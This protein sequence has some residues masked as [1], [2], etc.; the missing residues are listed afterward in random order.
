MPR[1]ILAFLIVF[2]RAVTFVLQNLRSVVPDGEFDRWYTPKQA[3]MKDDAVMRYF[4]TLRN[5]IEKQGKLEVATN[6]EIAYINFTEIQQ[7]RPPGATDFFMG[8]ER[9]GS[10]WDVPQADGT[11]VQ[12][13]ID[14]PPSTATVVQTFAETEAEG[15]QLHGAKVDDLSKHYIDSLTKLVNEAREKFLP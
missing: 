13:Y 2:G 7:Y 12:Y 4:V 6:V 9:G 15:H 1:T 11:V 3:K 10:G 5:E 8:D 14:L